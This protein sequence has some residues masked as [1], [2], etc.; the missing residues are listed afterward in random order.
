MSVET[1]GLIGILT[2]FVLMFLRVP[3]AIS[4][5]LPGIVGAWYLRGWGPTS[6]ILNTIIWN[7]GFNYTLT[8][9]PMFVLM[10]ELIY[11]S[12]ISSDLFSVFR[13]WLGA[14]KG[15]LG[16]ATVGASA[17]FAAAS[18]SSI[19]ST[20]TVGIVASGEMK[21]AGYSD[22]LS[23]GSIVAGGTLGILIPPSTAFII[24][25]ILTEESIGKLLIAGIIPGI[26]LTL[27]Y[28]VTVYIAVLINPKLGPPAE[29]A[30]WKE[31]LLALRSIG[32]IAALFIVVIGGMYAGI[33]SPTE[34]AGVGAL[35]AAIIAA[36]RGQMSFRNLATS[37]INTSRITAFLFAIILGAFIL[38]YFLA[39]TR[40]PAHLAGFINGLD[41][42]PLVIVLFILCVY[43]FLGAI[44]DA[45][46]MV[47]ITIPIFLPTLHALG[48]DMIWFGV[49]VVI[50]IELALITPPVGMGMFVLKGVNKELAMSSIYK[51]AVIFIV[52]IFAL[53]ALIV[54]FPQI[55][56]LLPNLMQ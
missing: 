49:I 26:L 31:R 45:L 39:I 7:H 12:G 11:V 1:V 40:L 56:T 16:L 9:I 37:L 20:A 54:T 22:T 42:S 43:I 52:P 53:V 27:F 4:M 34:A 41:A 44:M 35:G 8:T 51:G 13:K 15:G 46:A 47:V 33:F 6:T 23:A 17:L 3:I 21:K 50:M 36:I 29:S 19:A 28:A 30:T 10:G 48:F 32:W 38:N 24:Y 14:V 2:M 25:G 18:G 55:A 5:A